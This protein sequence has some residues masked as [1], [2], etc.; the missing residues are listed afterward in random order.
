MSSS[1]VLDLVFS[2]NGVLTQEQYIDIYDHSPTLSCVFLNEV[3][4]Y[5][6]ELVF[7]DKI[8]PILCNVIL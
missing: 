6:Y 4:E 1:E 5:E 3:E 2:Q 7:S 8:E